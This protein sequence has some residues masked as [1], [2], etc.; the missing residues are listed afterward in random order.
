MELARIILRQVA[1]PGT[2]NAM[3]ALLLS[4]EPM[5]Q[6]ELAKAIKKSQP[7]IS[8]ALAALARANLVT[9]HRDPNRAGSPGRPPVR[10]Q[11]AR[12]QWNRLTKQ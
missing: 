7:A 5:T 3:Q 11:P 4:D 12:E 9:S 2:W 10:W 1:G 6:A 8:R